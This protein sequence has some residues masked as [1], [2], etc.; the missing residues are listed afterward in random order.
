M[1]AER[2]EEHTVPCG[3]KSQGGINATG[4]D[5]SGVVVECDLSDVALMHLCGICLAHR[6]KLEFFERQQ[7][8]AN[9]LIETNL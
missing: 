2:A 3:P 8:V 5:P 4:K 7:V 1:A 6:N 9:K